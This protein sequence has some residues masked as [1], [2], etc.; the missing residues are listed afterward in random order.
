MLEDPNI[1]I[2][3]PE[4]CVGQVLVAG[5]AVMPLPASCDKTP[6]APKHQP[7]RRTLRISS[8]RYSRKSSSCKHLRNVEGEMA[9]EVW[10]GDVLLEGSNPC[11]KSASQ[12]TGSRTTHWSF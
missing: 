2:T 10:A 9:E 6:N 1:P 12:G 11:A 7:I 8:Q 5:A 4:C 3:H